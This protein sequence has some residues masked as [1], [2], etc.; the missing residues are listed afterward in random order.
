MKCFEDAIGKVSK[1]DYARQLASLR[2]LQAVAEA[3]R[4][5]KTRCRCV[6]MRAGLCD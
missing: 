1:K 6:Y 2:A 4:E 5:S 3:F